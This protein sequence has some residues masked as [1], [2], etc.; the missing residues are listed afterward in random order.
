MG[1]L[2]EGKSYMYHVV[3][4]RYGTAKYLPYSS[5][6][7][8]TLAGDVKDV[9]DEDISGEDHKESGGVLKGGI[10]AVVSILS[11]PAVSFARTK[12]CL[13]TIFLPN[14]QNA[15]LSCCHAAVRP[16]LQ[17]SLSVKITVAK[18]PPCPLSS[19]FSHKL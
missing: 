15:L 16:G 6:S 9:N 7:L 1:S 11:M 3:V 12:L 2:E 14:A 17:S 5:R 13:K 4:H 8:K 10:S 19:Q 18:K